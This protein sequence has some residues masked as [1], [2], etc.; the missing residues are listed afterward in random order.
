MYDVHF[1]LN[2]VTFQVSK[3][4]LE[5]TVAVKDRKDIGMTRERATELMKELFSFKDKTKVSL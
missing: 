3:A 1:F 4:M 2:L 5:L